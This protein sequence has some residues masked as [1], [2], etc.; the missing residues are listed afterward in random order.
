MCAA[1]ITKI[2]PAT[3]V[4][5][6]MTSV[7]SVRPN[8][9][10]PP[11]G[12]LP[13]SP[14]DHSSAVPPFTRTVSGSATSSAQSV[15]RRAAYHL[16]S[17]CAVYAG[18]CGNGCRWRATSAAMNSAAGTISATSMTATVRCI[19]STATPPGR[20]R[21]TRRVIPEAVQEGASRDGLTS[22]S[23]KTARSRSA[24]DLVSGPPWS[25]PTPCLACRRHWPWPSSVGRQGIVTAC[26]PSRMRPN[27]ARAR[28]D[29]LA[30]SQRRA[31]RRWP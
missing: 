11:G 2:T 1:T 20:G 3:A 7:G 17:R 29:H 13:P 23:P 22:R 30:A 6:A 10:G 9:T 26:R 25:A 16:T 8:S 4:A 15:Q 28:R 27:G 21:P 19:V 24:S 5:A 18:S 31:S 12:R 14:Q